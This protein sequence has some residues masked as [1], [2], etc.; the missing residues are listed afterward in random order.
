MA[1]FSAGGPQA[2]E[3]MG[4][5]TLAARRRVE[6]AADR[7]ADGGGG[8]DGGGGGY[9]PYGVALAED[10][11][12]AQEADPRDDAGGHPVVPAQEL[13]DVREQQ[14]AHRD[15]GERTDAGGGS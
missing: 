2:A 5:K 10:D 13:G 4:E 3:A 7:H 6:P 1:A 15:Q 14:R 12:R 9:P 11:A 8:P